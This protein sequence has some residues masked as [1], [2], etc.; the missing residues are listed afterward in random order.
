MD[1]EFL[2]EVP[3]KDIVYANE[4]YGFLEYRVR[5]DFVKTFDFS[6][7]PFEWQRLVVEIEHKNLNTSYLVYVRSSDHLRHL[8][9]VRR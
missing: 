4:T 5:G 8:S 3:S 2:N 1:F 6:R 9:S 7:Y